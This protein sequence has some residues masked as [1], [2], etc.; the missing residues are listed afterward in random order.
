MASQGQGVNLLFSGLWD[1][2]PEGEEPLPTPLLKRER[3]LIFETPR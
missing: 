1:I 3:D 2:F